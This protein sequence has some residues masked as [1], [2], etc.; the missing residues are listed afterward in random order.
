MVSLERFKNL[1]GSEAEKYSEEE[2][3]EVYKSMYELGQLMFDDW[4][5]QKIDSK[6]PVWG[7]NNTGDLDK[8]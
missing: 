6:H 8:I 4:L 2:L 5:S 1:L 3:E 7:F